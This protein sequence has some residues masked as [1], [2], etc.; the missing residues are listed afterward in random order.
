MPDRET[1]KARI[2]ELEAEMKK[3]GWWREG[4]PPPE[5]FDFH[6]AF[7]MD[8]MAFSQWLQFIFVPRVNQIIESGEQFPTHSSVGAQA[9]REF[10]G[11][12]DADRLCTLL[13]QFDRLIELG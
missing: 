10:D 5:A 3:I 9:V 4:P 2:D 6:K 11:E 12:P 8:T 1:V 7:A 13:S